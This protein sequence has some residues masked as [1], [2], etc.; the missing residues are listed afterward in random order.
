MVLLILCRHLSS[1]ASLGIR[2]QRHQP[3]SS[4]LFTYAISNQLEYRRERLSDSG[5]LLGDVLA[6]INSQCCS[7][8]KMKDKCVEFIISWILPVKESH[9]L[10][11]K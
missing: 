4:T 2:D 7:G 8:I 9:V 11:Y 3:F 6:M 5:V 1:L 10:V